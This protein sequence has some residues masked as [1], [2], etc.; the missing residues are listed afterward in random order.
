M[1]SLMGRGVIRTAGMLS[2]RIQFEELPGMLDDIVNRRAKTFK[3][4][5]DVNPE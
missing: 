1:L 4:I 3:V 5:V 2:H